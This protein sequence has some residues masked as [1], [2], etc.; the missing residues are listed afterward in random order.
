VDIVLGKI[1][2]YIETVMGDYQNGF[3][4]GRSVIDNIFVLKILNENIWEY[5]QSVQYLFLDFQ[6]AYDSIHR[7]TIWECMKEFKIPTKLIQMCKTCVQETR[8]AVR[9]EGTL[10]SF[11]ENI[12]G[13]KQGDCLSPI[14][15]NLA[16]QKVIQSIKMVR[17]G[18][19]IG[20]EQVNILAY[21]DDIVLIGK[22]DVEIRKLF[23]EME[24]IARKL[25]L[26]INQEKTK[27]MALERKS[28][29][30]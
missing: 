3:R 17:S 29:L 22:N 18:I 26:Q 1:K 7:D 8:S 10:S 27:Y 13:L 11:F 5:N 2:P 15:F 6:K 30:N 21:T 24:N 25:G 12:R 4:A 9:T 28:S 20:K 14:L 16:L 19:K 23:V